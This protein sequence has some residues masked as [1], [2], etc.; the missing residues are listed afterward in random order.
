MILHK[1]MTLARKLTTEFAQSFVSRFQKNA[2]QI[3]TMIMLERNRKRRR[4]NKQ[5]KNMKMIMRR[6]LL[7][8]MVSSLRT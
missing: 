4:K 6:K 3:H 1:L 5:Q 2:N 8:M 7:K